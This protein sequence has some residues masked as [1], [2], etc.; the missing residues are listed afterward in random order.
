[1]KFEGTDSIVI[2]KAFPDCGKIACVFPLWILFC[3]NCRLIEVSLDL[4]G[5]DGNEISVG[6]GSRVTFGVVD[7]Q[8]L[9]LF[10]GDINIVNGRLCGRSRR[11]CSEAQSSKP[12]IGANITPTAKNSGS[13]VLGVKIGLSEVTD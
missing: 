1:M 13:T 5:W 9:N 3:F 11:T 12:P 2:G 4:V 10:R 8:F 6:T 7:N